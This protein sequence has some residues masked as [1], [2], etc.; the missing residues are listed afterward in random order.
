[1]RV[2]VPPVLIVGAGPVGMVVAAELLQRDIPIRIIDADRG[3]ADHSRA[4]SLWPRILEL[5]DRIAV[6]DELICLAHRLDR[7]RYHSAGRHLGTVRLDALR[8]TPYPFGL[9]LPQSVTEDV[10]ERRLTELDGKIERGVRLTGLRPDGDRVFAEVETG[11]GGG[12]GIEASWVV[13]ADGAHSSV[14]SLLDVGFTGPEPSLDFAI[15]DARISGGLPQHMAGYCWSPA[16]ALTLAALGDDVFRIAVQVTP[17]QKRTQ[18]PAEYFEEVLHARGPRGRFSVGTVR[19]STTFNAAIRTAEQYRVGRCFLVGDAAH[20]M[21]PIGGQGMNTGIQDA[22]NLGWKLAGVLDGTLP[23][24]VLDTYEAERGDILRRDVGIRI[25]ALTGRLR[26][27]TALTLAQLST[28]YADQ[29]TAV[30]RPLRPGDRVPAVIGREKGGWLGLPV[31]RFTVLL[32]EPERIAASD[33]DA[34]ESA[35]PEGVCCLTA[36]AVQAPALVGGLGRAPVVA[37]IRPDGHLTAVLD[38][39][40][41]AAYFEKEKQE[42]LPRSA[43]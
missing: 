43:L 38:P 34:I 4:T 16:G 22:V 39:A 17:D 23:E 25:G 13:G 7:V 30:D 8:G 3:H 27:E 36:T 35:L 5:L 9:A 20:V 15:G 33:R 42:R 29:E 41:A 14:R 32:W 21:S 31:D 19:F 26:K 1:M 24:S 10:L 18:Y 6:T 2:L 40:R 28:T 37:L 12:A 11:D